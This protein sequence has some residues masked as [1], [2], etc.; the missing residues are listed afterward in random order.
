MTGIEQGSSRADAAGQ[1]QRPGVLPS[2]Q[3]NGASEREL[4]VVRR[5]IVGGHSSRGSGIG[6]VE[7]YGKRWNVVWGLAMACS[8]E[9]F[10]GASWSGCWCAKLGSHRGSLVICGRL[11]RALADLRLDECGEVGPAS[12]FGA[13]MLAL[14]VLFFSLDLGLRKGAR[15]SVEYAAYCAARAAATQIPRGEADQATGHGGCVSTEEREAI[16]H[17]AAAC[18]ASVGSKG[19]ALPL[20]LPGEISRLINRTKREH[21][22]RV[23]ILGPDGRES[24]CFTHN[25][26]VTAEV[27]FK[28]LLSIPLSPLSLSEPNGLVMTA[29]AS[30]MLHSVR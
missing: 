23:R 25:A 24:S 29:Q 7:V 1:R 20:E 28:Y 26:V 14:M 19:Q 5:E 16:T 27:R 30:Q 17:A 12:Y 3:V 2:E 21:E 6:L 15:L 4:S 11:P 22:V 8:C 9:L 18:L 13:F 10:R